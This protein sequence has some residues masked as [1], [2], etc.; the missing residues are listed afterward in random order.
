MACMHYFNSWK[1]EKTMK[2]KELSSPEQEPNHENC[3]EGRKGE[4][5]K[6]W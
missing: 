2:S 3:E 1:N 6:V 5:V 4:Q